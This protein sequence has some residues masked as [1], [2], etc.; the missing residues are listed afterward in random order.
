V[1]NLLAL[2]LQAGEPELTGNSPELPPGRVTGMK[3]E[4]LEARC[5]IAASRGPSSTGRRGYGYG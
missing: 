5:E 2:G 1:D 3:A 4:R